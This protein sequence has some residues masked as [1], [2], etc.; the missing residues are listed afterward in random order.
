MRGR[1]DFVVRVRLITSLVISTL[2]TPVL[3]NE[4]SEL[5][6]QLAEQHKVMQALERRMRELE[7]KEQERTEQEVGV[8][9]RGR[10]SQARLCDGG[11][12]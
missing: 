12:V 8:W 3:A 9:L 1:G 4:L 5:R 7:A 10:R 2:A 6:Q 11:C